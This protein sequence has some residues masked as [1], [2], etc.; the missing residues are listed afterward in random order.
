METIIHEYSTFILNHCTLLLQQ[1]VRLGT[2]ILVQRHQMRQL[3]SF[4]FR[5]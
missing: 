1:S 5:L 3:L 2:G 4:S